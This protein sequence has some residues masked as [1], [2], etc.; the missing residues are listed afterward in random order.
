MKD[1]YISSISKI[2]DQYGNPEDNSDFYITSFGKDKLEIFINC[3]KAYMAGIINEFVYASGMISRVRVYYH[4][5]INLLIDEIKK[6]KNFDSKESIYIGSEI[7]NI[8]D[9]ELLKS[10]FP[11]KKIVLFYN[12]ELA[13]IDDIISSIYMINYYKSIVDDDLSPLEKITIIYDIIKSHV[14]KEYEKKENTTF[15]RYITKIVKNNYIVCMGYVNLFNRVLKELGFH[16]LI[17]ELNIKKDKETTYH[18]RSMVRINDPK[19]NINN[20]F[21]FDPTWDSDHNAYIK[22]ENGIFDTNYGEKEGY[23]KADS[24]SCYE[25]FLVPLSS[26]ENK[27]SNS[28]NEK[29]DDNG[30]KVKDPQIINKLFH[31]N[32]SKKK[33]YFLPLDSFIKLIN[34]A[35]TEEGYPQSVIPGLIEEAL[36]LSDY[37]YVSEDYII[38]IINQDNIRL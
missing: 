22:I 38:N 1:D 7:N 16:S 8:N 18:V 23:R 3:Y 34:V 6:D 5:D 19:Y 9:L 15:S 26:Y 17:L 27:F 4:S 12:N 20:Y 24:L 13:F 10:T 37:G 36:I 29:L 30:K 33:K 11:N 14:Y 35:K 28:F 31:E 2:F 21:I 25:H 32:Q